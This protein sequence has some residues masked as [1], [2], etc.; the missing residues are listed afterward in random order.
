MR[1]LSAVPMST[2]PGCSAGAIAKAVIEFDDQ[3]VSIPPSGR[4]R[5]TAL[6][7]FAVSL[8]LRAEACICWSAA[9]VSSAGLAIDGVDDPEDSAGCDPAGFGGRVVVAASPRAST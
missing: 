5:K 1:P 8:R 6:R 2:L 4:I 7:A 3:T 9:P